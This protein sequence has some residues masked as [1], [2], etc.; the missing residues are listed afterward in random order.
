MKMPKPTV[1]L[2]LSGS[3]WFHLCGVWFCSFNTWWKLI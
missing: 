3:F 1:G 2:G